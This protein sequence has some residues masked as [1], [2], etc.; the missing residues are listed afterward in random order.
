MAHEDP[1]EEAT[2]PATA[3]ER[4]GNLARH[5]NREV[6]RAAW[7]NPSLPEDVWRWALLWGEP[8]AWDNPMAPFYLLTWTPR[9]GDVISLEFAA[10]R[11]MSDLWRDPERCSPEGKALLAAKVQEGWSTSASADNMMRFLVLWAQAKGKGSPEQREVLRILVLC[12]RTAPD[13]TAEDRQALDLLEAWT[14]GSEDRRD[15]AETL[16]SFQPVRSAVLVALDPRYTPLSTIREVLEAVESTAGKQAR[17]EHSRLLA[18][19]IRR[20]MPLPPVIA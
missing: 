4:L 19:V 5:G 8:E 16:A 20:E 15:E 17:D 11:A 3:P 18:D 1:L 2:D 10:Q 7:R 13:L 12:V 9:E 14:A 6:K